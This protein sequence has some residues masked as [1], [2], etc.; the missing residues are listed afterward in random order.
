[1]TT[2]CTAYRDAKGG[3]HAIPAKATLA[4]LAGCSDVSGKRVK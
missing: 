3:L 2:E 4:D 1:M